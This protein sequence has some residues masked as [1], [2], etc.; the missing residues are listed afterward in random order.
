ML[1]ESDPVEI[2][3]VFCIAVFW[4]PILKIFLETII[5]SRYF[6]KFFSSKNC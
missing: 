3:Y 5:V 4:T 1:I 2:L 6:L